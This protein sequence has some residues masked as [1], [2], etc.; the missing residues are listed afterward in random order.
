MIDAEIDYIFWLQFIVDAPVNI[1]NRID[2]YK[3]RI[4][5]TL[6]TQ[7]FAFTIHKIARTT[8]LKKYWTK[9]KKML[10]I[11]ENTKEFVGDLLFCKH[12]QK[13][14]EMSVLDNDLSSISSHL[15]QK[16]LH[17]KLLCDLV[18]P[19]RNFHR[20][21]FNSVVL[22]IF[23]LFF[24][25]QLHILGYSKYSLFCFGSLFVFFFLNIRHSFSFRFSSEV[26]WNVQ[27]CPKEYQKKM[28]F[29]FFCC[30][31]PFAHIHSH[32]QSTST[33]RYWKCLKMPDRF[34]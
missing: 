29:L 26:F 2:L 30:R 24:W 10:K 27:V 19:D 23:S 14:K 22:N 9:K 20:A 18:F 3:Y 11:C 12:I 6:C 25:F 21:L 28:S 1:E 16:H 32:L 17:T 13:K 15:S 34:W 8:V 33:F 7:H 4:F 5:F 31:F